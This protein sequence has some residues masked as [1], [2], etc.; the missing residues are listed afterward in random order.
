MFRDSGTKA[1]VSGLHN[2]VE[3]GEPGVPTQAF[4]HWFKAT[5][6]NKMF[7]TRCSEHAFQD[8]LSTTCYRAPG[9][10]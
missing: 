5:F 1:P 10:Q 3:S 2:R 7:R 4:E 6:P 8:H 9:Y